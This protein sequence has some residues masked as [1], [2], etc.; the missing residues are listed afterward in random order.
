MGELSLFRNVICVN[1]HLIA[2][3]ANARGDFPLNGLLPMAMRVAAPLLRWLGAMGRG[4]GV[5]KVPVN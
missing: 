5:C 3:M 1:L 2:L 4:A